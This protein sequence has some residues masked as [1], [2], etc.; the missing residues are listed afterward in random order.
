MKRKLDQILYSL[1]C[2]VLTLCAVLIASF[3]GNLALAASSKA[4]DT[5]GLSAAAGGESMY[6]FM[7]M[8]VCPDAHNRV[9]PGLTPMDC[10]N[11]RKIRPGENIPYHLSDFFHGDVVCRPGHHSPQI[12][13]HD[14]VPMTYNGVTRTVSAVSVGYDRCEAKPTP[15]PAYY[16]VHWVGQY[17]FMMGAWARGPNNGPG[18]VGGGITP[19]CAYGPGT[20]IQYYDFWVLGPGLAPAPGA[21][22][23]GTFKTHDYNT[24]LPPLSAACPTAFTPY[25]ALWA[26][27]DFTFGPRGAASYT[28]DTVVSHPYSQAGVT[29]TTPGDSKQAE[30]TYWTKEFGQTRWEAWK[31]DDFVNVQTG[32]TAEQLALAAFATC[33]P[34]YAFQGEVTPNTLIGA[35]NQ[36]GSYNQTV[37]D[38]STGISHVWYMADCLDMTHIAVGINP[39]GDPAP[40]GASLGSS[41][42]WNF[43]VPRPH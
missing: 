28:L 11:P 14:N 31:R 21:V 22:G 30:R 29:G 17:A 7:V 40:S 36:N 16:E 8:S 2:G 43:W 38:Q 26:R 27:G 18:S 15:S 10:A 5:D 32:Q 42:F 37:T 41:A 19:L 23:Y 34:P 20:S 1:S 24:G 12:D 39:A 25:L 33:T 6:D 4:I 9:I 35:L 3:N 13:I